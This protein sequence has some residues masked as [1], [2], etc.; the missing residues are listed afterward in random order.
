MPAGSLSVV[1]HSFAQ[2]LGGCGVSSSISSPSYST[3]PRGSIG[4]LGHLR[5]RRN[6]KGQ[7]HMASV[8]EFFEGLIYENAWIV[9]KTG[10]PISDLPLSRE[11]ADTVRKLAN[12]IA[13]ELGIRIEMVVSEDEA[14]DIEFPAVQLCFYREQIIMDTYTYLTNVPEN[15]IPPEILDCLFGLLYGYRSDA[16]QQYV[17]WQQSRWA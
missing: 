13:D 15:D 16:I 10:K 11:D 8:N 14:A 4:L 6:E 12:D 1:R 3:L 17:D 2:S 5:G 9:A 7:R